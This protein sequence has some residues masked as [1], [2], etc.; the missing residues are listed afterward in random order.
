M[1]DFFKPKARKPIAV[2][3]K[4]FRKPPEQARIVAAPRERSA[5]VVKEKVLCFVIVKKYVIEIEDEPME[6]SV[7]IKVELKNSGDINKE[8][9]KFCTK[10]FFFILYHA[11]RGQWKLSMT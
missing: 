4:V 3:M 1:F 9:E 8:I 7:N 2:E 11:G 10:N 6:K 5:K